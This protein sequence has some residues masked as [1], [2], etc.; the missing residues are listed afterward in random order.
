[1]RRRNAHSYLYTIKDKSVKEEDLVYATVVG[2]QS[3]EG[4]GRQRLENNNTVMGTPCYTM[5]LLREDLLHIVIIR[6]EYCDYG[7]KTRYILYNRTT[8]LT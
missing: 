4:L 8:I 1:M 7:F 2:Q 3:F 6:T 5:C